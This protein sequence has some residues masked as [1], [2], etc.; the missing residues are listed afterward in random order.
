MAHMNM[1]WVLDLR[2]L[3]VTEK[4][5]LTV[6]TCHANINTGE[7]WPSLNLIADEAGFSRGSK[8]TILKALDSLEEKGLISRRHQF[9]AGGG[10]TS[11]LY[12]VFVGVTY[13]PED[14]VKPST[15]VADSYHPSSSQ[16]LPQ[17]STAT[18]L[19]ADSYMNREENKEVN[20]SL[21][22]S[23]GA[24]NSPSLSDALKN[25]PVIIPETARA[26]LIESI[27]LCAQTMGSAYSSEEHNAAEDDLHSAIALHLGDEAQ[28][29][30]EHEWKVA[31]PQTTPAGAEKKLNHFIGHMV[32]TGC[33]ITA[34]EGA[35]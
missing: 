35:A 29:V 27:Q 21:D 12:T 26:D 28:E 2:G 6:L 20:R 11:N 10:K 14:S 30:W 4:A 7:C 22:M 32:K 19:V 18:T 9:K 24:L 8:Q 34:M 15:L 16:P 33:P 31:G 23:L 1:N 3:N 5:V 25:R 17:W 13:Q